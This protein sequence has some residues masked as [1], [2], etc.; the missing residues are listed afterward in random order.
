MIE[1]KDLIE[2]IMIDYGNEDWVYTSPSIS[3]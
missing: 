1:S 2:K 3:E